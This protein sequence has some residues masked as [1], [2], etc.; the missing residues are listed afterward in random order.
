MN[1]IYTDNFLYALKELSLRLQYSSHS[2]EEVTKE[3]PVSVQLFIKMYRKTPTPLRLINV[4]QLLINE[5]NDMDE[6]KRDKV[7]TVLF[8]YTFSKL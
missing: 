3:L 2:V 7:G 5:L 1:A 6:Q 8:G 4:A